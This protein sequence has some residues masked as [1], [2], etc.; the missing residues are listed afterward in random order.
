MLKRSSCRQLLRT[1]LTGIANVEHGI[2]NEVDIVYALDI[3]ELYSRSSE[4]IVI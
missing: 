1:L 3:P 4:Y 2:E